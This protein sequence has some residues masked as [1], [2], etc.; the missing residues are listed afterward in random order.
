MQIPEI[1]TER[2]IERILDQA[3]SRKYRLIFS[4]MAYCG[5]RSCEVTKLKVTD[6]D[7]SQKKI[8]IR[9]ETSKY[10]KSGDI[11]P[12]KWLLEELIDFILA[13]KRKIQWHND[14]IFFS[15]LD[16]YRGHITTNSVRIYFRRTL[17]ALGL[18]IKVG[19]WNK[20]A[21]KNP[22]YKYSTHTLRHWFCS[23]VYRKTH[24]VYAVKEM[25]RHSTVMASEV[26]IHTD[27]DHK[28]EIMSKVFASPNFEK[29]MLS[30]RNA[31]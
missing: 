9:A 17:K 13:H 7:L 5:L 10:N 20:G 30:E 29:Q 4:I 22:K 23:Q 6:I 18:L 11:F 14:Y 1:P 24:D 15:N 3:P 21:N 25:A 28:K 8:R 19:T 27:Y 2:E 31:E 26:Y 12:P 16:S